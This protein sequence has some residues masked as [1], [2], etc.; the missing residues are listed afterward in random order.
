[1]LLWTLSMQVAQ[2]MIVGQLLAYQ[3]RWQE[4]ETLKCYTIK[5]LEKAVNLVLF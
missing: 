4:G 2:S 1:L 5:Y 3:Q